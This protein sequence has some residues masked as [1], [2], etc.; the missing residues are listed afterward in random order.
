VPD[1]QANIDKCLTTRVA[2]LD[3]NL[4]VNQPNGLDAHVFL[5]LQGYQGRIFFFTGH[6]RNHPLVQAAQNLGRADILIKP[7]PM[8]KLVNYVRGE[9]ENSDPTSNPLFL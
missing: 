8:D 7:V 6:A 3:I 1:L 4:G 9:F 2:F 5:C